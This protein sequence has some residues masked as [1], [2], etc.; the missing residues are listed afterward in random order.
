MIG[1]HLLLLHE[2][3]IVPTY[4]NALLVLLSY[5]DDTA[6]M[7]SLVMLM[8]LRAI[9]SEV[10]VNQHVGV[11]VTLS[12]TRY[13]GCL[14]YLRFFKTVLARALP[15][16]L[17]AGARVVGWRLRLQHAVDT[18]CVYHLMGLAPTHHRYR[19]L[20]VH[21]LVVIIASHCGELLLLLHGRE[22]TNWD[23]RASFLLRHADL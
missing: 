12:I 17:L 4:L 22:S 13:F 6:M 8:P 21:I 18:V 10:R 20:I 7:V 9:R 16:M 23:V 3:R 11:I 19:H 14:R 1:N 2:G 5:A 15:T